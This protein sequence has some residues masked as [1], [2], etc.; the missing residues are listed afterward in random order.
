MRRHPITLLLSIAAL[1]AALCGCHHRPAPTAGPP[2]PVAL[3]ADQTAEDP[4]EPWTKQRRE[5]ITVA[6]DAL[7]RAGVSYKV[8]ALQRMGGGRLARHKVA[9]L[10]YARQLTALQLQCLLSF[11]KDGGRLIAAHRLPE[12]LTTALGVQVVGD[13]CERTG[14]RYTG[15]ELADVPILGAPPVFTQYSW[16]VV[17]ARPRGHRAR[18]LYFW[19]DS[20]GR[21]TRAPAVI[22]SSTGAYLTHVLTK[23][24]R[25]TK[26]SLLAAL[27]GYFA[28]AVWPE[29]ASKAIGGVGR[30]G[31]IESLDKLQE[32]VDEAQAEGRAKGADL[33]LDVVRKLVSGARRQMAEQGYPKAIATAMQ[34]QRIAAQAYVR[35]FPTRDAEMRGVWL[36]SPTGAN[37][38]DWDE[39]IRRLSRAGFNAVFVNVAWGAEAAYKSHYVPLSPLAKGK[40]QLALCVAACRKYGVE[41]HAWFLNYYLGRCSPDVVCRLK[42]RGLLQKDK[43]GRTVEWLCPSHPANYALLKNL[44]LEVVRRYDVDGIQFDYVRYPDQSTCYCARC[45]AQ[46]EEQVGHK[47][48]TWPS[49]LFPS[50]YMPKYRQWR[51]DRITRLVRGVSVQA[52]GMRRRIKVSAAVR[53]NWEQD[54]RVVGQDWVHWVREGYLDFVCPM[55]YLTDLELLRR[56]VNKQVGWVHGQA[57]VYVGLGS[58]QLRDVSDLADQMALT[59][60]LGADGYVLFHYSDRTLTEDWMPILRD[61][62]AAI[63]AVTPHSSPGSGLRV[64]AGA[65]GRNTGWHAKHGKPFTVAGWV[66]EGSGIWGARLELHTLDGEVQNRGRRLYIDKRREVQFTPPPGK[67]RP[68][69]TGWASNRPFTRKGT[70]VIVEKAGG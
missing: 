5:Y 43:Q 65:V 26:A 48:K 68:V 38:W 32:M 15:C 10:P 2:G 28:P 31:R 25:E 56:K 22:L 6:A 36:Q 35:T 57:P 4:D 58:W 16:H 70:I 45:K 50:R 34:A 27:V 11:I 23:T 53:P 21:S 40:D 55:D 51:T 47:F 42:A 29:A 33:A 3:I 59:R 41:C 37:G 69:I 7:R 61:G 66:A 8:L 39:S 1:A 62:P 14:S 18:T 9:I 13:D 20:A 60:R 54:R 52:H 44:M 63:N 67:Y 49:D 24:D 19:Q 46:F 17:R 12:E 64:V 30:V